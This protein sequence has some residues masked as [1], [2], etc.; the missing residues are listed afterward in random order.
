MLLGALVQ[1][2][3]AWGRPAQSALPRRAVDS[4]RTKCITYFTRYIDFT[5]RGNAGGSPKRSGK[6][7]CRGSNN[8]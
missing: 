2:G 1:D 5:F 7:P 4:L 6:E 3:W 8:M